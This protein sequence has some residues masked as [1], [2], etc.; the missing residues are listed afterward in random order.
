MSNEYFCQKCKSPTKVGS[1]TIV[2]ADEEEKEYTVDQVFVEAGDYDYDTSLNIHTCPN[3][4]TNF[5]ILIWLWTTK[6]YWE[7]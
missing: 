2:S 4:G 5:T 6:I 1:M 7:Q 3:C